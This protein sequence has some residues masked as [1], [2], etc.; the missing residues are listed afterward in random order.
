MSSADVGNEAFS[1]RKEDYLGLLFYNILNINDIWFINLK[2]ET[3]EA[4]EVFLT[5]SSYF[6]LFGPI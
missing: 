5:I 6:Y 3:F 4:Q 1:V 2:T